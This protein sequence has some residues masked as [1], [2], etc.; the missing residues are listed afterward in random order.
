MPPRK[1][2][3]S[4]VPVNFWVGQWAACPPRSVRMYDSLQILPPPPENDFS[5]PPPYAACLCVGDVVV[6]VV[7]VVAV[8]VVVVVAVVVVVVVVV[9]IIARERTNDSIVVM[10][11]I[12]CPPLLPSLSR[13]PISCFCPPFIL[14]R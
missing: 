12:W 3:L 6:V 11:Q 4:G 2:I 13:P 14:Y 8:V 5:L 7:V 10:T 1:C 9:V